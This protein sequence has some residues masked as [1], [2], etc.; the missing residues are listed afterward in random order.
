[1]DHC[2]PAATFVTI[3]LEVAG[4]EGIRERAHGNCV[5]CSHSN[6]QGLQLEFRLCGDGS[7]EATFACDKEYEG[8][9]NIL[10]GG[11][12]SCLMDGAMTNCMFAHGF[13]ALTAEMMIRFRQ[14]VV[15]GVPASVRAWIDRSR[16]G[17]HMVK[18]ELLQDQFIKVTAN[19]KFM[20]YPPLQ[21]GLEDSR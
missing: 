3:E 8:Y 13:V 16:K 2:K 10:H 5:V 9:M 12:I 7:V 20:K 17:L 14:P 15:V 6:A 18:A 4:L 19:G 11:V 1:M 21:N